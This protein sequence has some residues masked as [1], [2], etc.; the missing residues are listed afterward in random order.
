YVRLADGS[1]RCVATNTFTVSAPEITTEVG[2]Y[3]SAKG[4]F[5]VTVS[6]NS[7]SGINEVLVPVWSQSGQTDIKWYKAVKQSDGTYKVTVDIKNHNSNKGKYNIHVYM[8]S[9]NG[10][11][12]G[13]IANSVTV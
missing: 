9:Q 5:D 3:D 11:T 13:K 8:Y 2:A 6:G 12:A 4:T 7:K 1:M 10:V